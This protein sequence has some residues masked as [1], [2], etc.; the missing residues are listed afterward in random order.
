MKHLL[1]IQIR[2]VK[3]SSIVFTWMERC[4]VYLPQNTLSV[5][6]LTEEIP[7]PLSFRRRR[8]LI[9]MALDALGSGG[10]I[11]AILILL[12]LHFTFG[13]LRIVARMTDGL[14][15]TISMLI[16]WESS[17]FSGIVWLLLADLVRS[18]LSGPSPCIQP[19][20]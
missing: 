11:Y 5:L 3:W 9:L 20:M 14:W 4:T 6:I 12:E 16:I 17:G 7:V 15:F 8:D 1:D 13:C 10:A 18:H 19:L 2:S